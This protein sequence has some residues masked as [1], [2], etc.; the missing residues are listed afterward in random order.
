[1]RVVLFCCIVMQMA[2]RACSTQ[3]RALFWFLARSLM[4]T[5]LHQYSRSDKPAF[6][7][8]AGF[9]LYHHHPRQPNWPPLRRIHKHLRSLR[10]AI[11]HAI[12]PNTVT[13]A[14]RCLKYKYANSARTTAL[15]LSCRRFPDNAPPDCATGYQIWLRCWE[16]AMVRSDNFH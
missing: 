5:T 14:C 6:I 1:M 13:P 12:Q 11:F 7:P 3:Q 9:P 2:G 15:S 16:A 4:P 8:T 10:I